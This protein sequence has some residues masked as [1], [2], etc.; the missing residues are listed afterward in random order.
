MSR[1]EE[2]E[3]IVRGNESIKRI[4]GRTARGY[5]SPA[6]DLSP[7][8]IELLLK[9]GAKKIYAGVSHAVLGEKGRN[10]ILKSPIVELLATNSTPQATGEKVIAKQDAPELVCLT[11]VSELSLL[12]RRLGIHATIVARH[13]QT[14]REG[15]ADVGLSED[16]CTVCAPSLSVHKAGSIA[17]W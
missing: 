2:E 1:E 17:C 11:E 8:S 10:R 14:P 16:V 6:W 7:N 12:Y 4:S 15:G 9:H 13:G 5:R 3:E